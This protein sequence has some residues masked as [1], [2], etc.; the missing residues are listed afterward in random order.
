M[1]KNIILITNHPELEKGLHA[2]T[3]WDSAWHYIDKYTGWE[4]S[5]PIEYLAALLR[6][7]EYLYEFQRKRKWLLELLGKHS[8]Y[9]EKELV[10]KLDVD[11]NLFNDEKLEAVRLSLC[12]VLMCEVHV[13]KFENGCVKITVS[14]PS[15]NAEEIFPLSPAK[16]EE[17][18][19]A[20]PSIISVTCGKIKESF[21]VSVFHG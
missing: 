5:R 13:L 21:T 16:K 8:K 12:N 4:N 20:F 6:D 1:K 2:A 15:E 3:S 11:Y 10:L 9:D 18:R 19:L 17:F 14:I 7:K